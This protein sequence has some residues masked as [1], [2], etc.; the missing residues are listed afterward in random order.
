MAPTL[1]VSTLGTLSAQHNTKPHSTLTISSKRTYWNKYINLMYI[2]FRKPPK[3]A[4]RNRSQQQQQQQQSIPLEHTHQQQQHP[5]QL[6]WDKVCRE[7]WPR[8]HKGCH[9]VYHV[10][11]GG[12]CVSPGG[13]SAVYLA[14]GDCFNC[15]RAVSLA[16]AYHRWHL[17]G[18]L[19]RRRL[20]H[21]RAQ[22]QLIDHST[23][24]FHIHNGGCHAH[25]LQQHHT[26]LLPTAQC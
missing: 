13:A 2:Y 3:K 25:P 22:S 11:Y 18:P 5:A 10:G 9:V 14:C 7:L 1:P 8:Q 26:L 23:R 19:G 20:S 12:G 6:G 4:N 16:F 21:G 17:N 15:E 24:H